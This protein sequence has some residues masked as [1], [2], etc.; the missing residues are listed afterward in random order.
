MKTKIQLLIIIII[1]FIPRLLDLSAFLTLDESLWLDRSRNFL[2]A[3]QSHDW[4]ETF[5]TGHPGVITMWSGCLGLLWYGLTHGLLQNGTFTSFLQALTWDNRPLD[6][7]FYLRLPTGIITSVGI[8]GIYYL[9]NR[10][11]SQ[12][13]ALVA[14]L[15][16]AFDPIYLAH[17]R[18]L[19]HDAL[20]TAF[21]TLSA[22]A[23]LLYIWRER[24]PWVLLLSGMCAGLA[25]LS[26][27]L[28]LFLLPWAGLLFLLALFVGRW[29]LSQVITDGALWGLTAWLTFFLLWPAMWL[30]P[31]NTLWRM[32]QMATTYAI[33]PHAQGQFFLGQPV[34]DPGWL[35]YPVVALFAMTPAVMV[36]LLITVV[37]SNDFSRSKRGLTTEVVT[38]GLLLVYIV[39]YL[40]FI[41]LG[42]KKR[43]NYLLPSLVMLNVVAAVGMNAVVAQIGSTLSKR[44][45]SPAKGIVLA[46]GVLLIGQAITSLPHHPY[47]FTYYNPLLGGNQVAVRNLLVGWGEGNE[48]AAEYLNHLPNAEK[49]KVVANKAN[50][51][52]PYFQGETL[53]WHPS[54]KVL[55]ADYVVL[56]RRDVQRGLPNPHLLDYIHQNW[57][58]EKTITLHGLAYA[59]IYRAPAAD[60]TLSIQDEG[61]RSSIG[62]SGV[63][64]YRLNRSSNQSLH[65]TLYRQHLPTFNQQWMVQVEGAN[66]RWDA[67]PISTMPSPT[68]AGEIIEEVYEVD[69]KDTIPDNQFQ[70]HIGFHE[71][72]AV[73]WLSLPTLAMIK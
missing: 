38:T 33:N 53:L 16:L 26:K 37:R 12:R 68:E 36:G 8:G 49:L 11:F 46:T 71:G 32:R 4:G 59:W 27:S 18:I 56:Y 44:S 5:Q 55:E 17:S 9:L 67:I 20:L 40:L 14:G 48:L 45:I 63:L 41:S 31:A 35:F 39:A 43:P 15:L 60:W 57:P 54:A 19:H 22:L 70:V 24:V 62:R 13:V 73:E 50:T 1:A 23:L 2:L 72:T 29:P 21:M 66:R 69:F 30:N 65:V 7:L 28:G 47:Y 64:G 10:L 42:E 25:L 61:Q 3:L 52:S 58:L 6:L 51:F 34:T